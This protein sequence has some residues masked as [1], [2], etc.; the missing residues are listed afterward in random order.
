MWTEVDADKSGAVEFGEFF[1]MLQQYFVFKERDEEV[2]ALYK[3]FRAM[4][5]NGDGGVSLAEM[6][7]YMLEMGDHPLSPEEWHEYEDF[8]K[9]ADKDAD[10]LITV[11]DYVHAMLTDDDGNPL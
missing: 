3:A 9:R 10:G 1:D 11:T 8:F 7:K 6:K 4:D 5:Y 2:E